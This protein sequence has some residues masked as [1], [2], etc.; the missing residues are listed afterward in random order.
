M[1]SCV[2]RIEETGNTHRI[3]VRKP[4]ERCQAVKSGMCESNFCIDP[5][6]LN[7]AVLLLS[8]VRRS[9]FRVVSS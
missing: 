6:C 1:R 2:V 4:C 5:I 7:N 3:F 8:S 9:V